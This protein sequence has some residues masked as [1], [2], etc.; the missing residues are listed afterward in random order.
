M[1]LLQNKNDEKE[2]RVSH[3]SKPAKEWLNQKNINV[4][5]SEHRPESNWISVGGLEACCVQETPSQFDGCNDLKRNSKVFF[6][7]SSPLHN[8]WF[9]NND[10]NISNNLSI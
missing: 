10:G 1:I 4:F 7:S 2:L 5:E 3:T 8:L 9:Q 6:L